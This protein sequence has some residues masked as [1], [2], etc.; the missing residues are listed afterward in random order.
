MFVFEI[1]I[2]KGFFIATFD[3]QRVSV[4]YCQDCEVVV[5]SFLLD[6]GQFWIDVNHLDTPILLIV[7]ERPAGA[8]DALS[9]AQLFEQANDLVTLSQ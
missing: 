5:A 3:Y 6:A 1:S 9:I 4:T 8:D 2:C 7:R